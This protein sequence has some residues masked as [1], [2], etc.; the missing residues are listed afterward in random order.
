MI[1]KPDSQRKFHAAGD[2][3][4]KPVIVHFPVHELCYPGP[5]TAANVADELIR[6]FEENSPQK[7]SVKHGQ[8]L[9]NAL[10][11][12]LKTE[13]TRPSYFRL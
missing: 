10:E 2:R 8:M 12:T 5:L 13:N 11:P 3:F 1:R 7:D 4:L 6:I 9:W